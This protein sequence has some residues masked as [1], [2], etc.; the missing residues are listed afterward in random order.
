[1]LIAGDSFTVLMYSVKRMPR[2]CASTTS[3]GG[4]RAKAANGSLA[5]KKTPIDIKELFQCWRLIAGAD[6][7]R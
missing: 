4:L 2:R 3:R 1:M 7:D 6:I 5:L